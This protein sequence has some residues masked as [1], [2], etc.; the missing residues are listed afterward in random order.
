M[1]DEALEDGRASWEPAEYPE[2]DSSNIERFLEERIAAQME[3][4]QF[5]QMRDDRAEAESDSK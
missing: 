1:L 4:E 3:E 5:D 2:V